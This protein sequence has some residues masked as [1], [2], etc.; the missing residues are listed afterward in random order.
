MSSQDSAES[1]YTI[2]IANEQSEFDIDEE[3]IREAI[4]HTLEQESVVAADISVAV[5]DNE[6]IHEL[7]RRYLSHDYATDVL[8]FLLDETGPET[9]R[10]AE[11]PRGAGK[12]IE[13][14]LIV[15][16]EMASQ[17]AKEYRWS[18]HDELL[19]YIVHGLLHLC[20]Y[21]DLSE[22]E[23]R[24]MR[25]REREVLAHWNLT[26]HYQDQGA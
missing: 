14:E 4:T 9:A 5:I 24:I 1:K 12:S 21:D 25:Q 13:G 16:S 6:Q 3:R 15:S 10:N 19:L 7:N 2:E 26:P 20:G 8:S 17:V 22:S 11:G 18:P 23:Q